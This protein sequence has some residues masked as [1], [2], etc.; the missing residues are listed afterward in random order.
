MCSSLLRV[1]GCLHPVLFTLG[2]ACGS[3]LLPKV[4]A[5]C[6]NSASTDLCGGCPV[7]GIP[8]V[9]L[10]SFAGESNSGGIGRKLQTDCV[11]I[12]IEWE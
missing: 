2:P 6:G 3:P 4:G 9:P 1:S 8:T 5:V 11:R 10:A 7:R 12:E